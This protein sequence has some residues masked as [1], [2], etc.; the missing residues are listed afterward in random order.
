MATRARIGVSG[1]VCSVPPTAVF[2][3]EPI[4]PNHVLAVLGGKQMSELWK[5]IFDFF[6]QH[7]REMERNS[8]AFRKASRFS[9]RTGNSATRLAVSY[10]IFVIVVLLC[11]GA[12]YLA[13][14]P[15]LAGRTKCF[16]SRIDYNK[17]VATDLERNCE[18]QRLIGL[19][20]DNG[21]P[22]SDPNRGSLLVRSAVLEGGDRKK[23][24]W[25]EI[26]VPTALPE[27]ASKQLKSN[28]TWLPLAEDVDA[29]NLAPDS[30]EIVNPGIAPIPKN[31]GR[32]GFTLW[33]GPRRTAS[34]LTD[35][36]RLACDYAA[37][38]SDVKCMWRYLEMFVPS[39][40]PEE[41][42]P[43]RPLWAVWMGKREFTLSD[44]P[45]LC[46]RTR[47]TL[48]D[49]AIVGPWSSLGRITSVWCD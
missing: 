24:N 48:D 5:A 42:C 17:I 29:H 45:P 13:L 16:L 7:R 34:N 25:Y 49:K 11:C 2:R 41:F 10:P 14:N 18:E 23:G 27:H 32:R 30:C 47:T 40:E 9:R 22:R 28:F 37:D 36:E 3:F 12:F 35:A 6:K 46:I 44:K 1:I 31:I 15:Q 21:Q 19:Y 26:Y 4:E 43:D 39:A 8:P 33:A 38:N 20:W